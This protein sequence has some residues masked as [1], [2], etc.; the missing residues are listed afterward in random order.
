MSSDRPRRTGGRTYSVGALALIV[1]ASLGATGCAGSPSAGGTDAA[2]LEARALRVLARTPLIDGHNDVPWQYRSRVNLHLDEIDLASDTKQLEPAMHTDI[3]RLRAGG[4]GAQFWSVYIPAKRG[5]AQPGD[6][7]ILIEQIDFTRRMIDRYSDTFELAETADDIVRIHRKGKIA[8]L[9]GIEGGH[10]IEHSLGV[11]RIAYLAGARYMGLTHTL[12]AA[13]ADSGTDDPV[14]GGLTEF[15]REVVRE[16]NRMGML[17][18]LAHTSVETM[19]D[20]LDIAQAP[21]IFSHA[22]ARAVTDHPRNVPDDVL[23]RVKENGGVVMVTF[24][25]IYVSRGAME[26]FEARTAKMQE[27][28]DAHPEDAERVQEEIAAWGKAHPRVRATLSDVADHIDH[29][30]A[31][32]GAEHV[33]IGGDYDGITHLPI[34]LEDVSKY[35]A[36]FAELYR[37]GWSDAEIEMIAGQNLLR[38]M[39]GAERAAARLQRERAPSDVRMEEVDQ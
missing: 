26:W 19:H 12:N 28:Q 23:D 25:P 2:A 31:R 11:L 20:T 21:V 18:D 17:V 34:G 4:M 33:G 9:M 15:G 24:V 27:L 38:A 1:G 32:I 39:R 22:S 30:R 10:S 16:M 7:R 3:D 35:P 6:G 37:R 36:L 13:W 8:S 29:I 14:S 5:G